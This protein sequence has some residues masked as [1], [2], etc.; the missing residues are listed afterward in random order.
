MVDLASD[1]ASPHLIVCR[2]L[3][4]QTG[5]FTKGLFKVNI[6]LCV[7]PNGDG[8]GGRDFDLMLLAASL[9]SKSMHSLS[10][11]IARYPNGLS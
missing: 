4:Y 5:T 6:R 2:S 10:R 8:N 9:E 1:A 3:P 11:A 7:G